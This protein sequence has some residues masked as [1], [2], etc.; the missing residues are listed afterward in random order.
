VTAPEEVFAPIPAF[1]GYFIGDRGTVLS[2]KRGRLAELRP[3]VKSNGYHSVN[4]SRQIEGNKTVTVH[5]LVA[6][7]F[8]G[9]RPDGMI[10]LHGDGT[11]TNSDVRNLRWGTP[12]DNILDAF[13]HGTMRPSSKR[14][15]QPGPR[16]ACYRG[17]PFT[18]E[19]T[20]DWP[21][22]GGR[23]CRICYLNTRKSI[24]EARKAA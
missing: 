9:P 24:R 10:V 19:N 12:A 2:T 8:I 21:S 16:T 5:T 3:M 13:R 15:S 6:V 23:R 11:R 18:D 4:L 14:P 22:S 17:H 1:P 7:A 20:Y